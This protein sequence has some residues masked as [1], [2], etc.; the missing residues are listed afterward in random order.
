MIAPGP[1]SAPVPASGPDVAGRR[2]LSGRSVA[3]WSVRTDPPPAVAAR[4]EALLA[5]D[6]IARANRFLGEHLRSAYV[7]AH[8]ALRIL[9]GRY[10]GIAPRDVRLTCGAQGKPALAPPAGVGFNLSHSGHLATF[11]FALDCEL[12]IDVEHE[13]PVADLQAIAARFFSP[14]EALELSGVHPAAERERAFF[15]CWTRKEAYVKAVGTGLS[16]PLDSFRV[17]L[18]TGEPPRLMGV[19]GDRRGLED[20]NLH[21]LAPAPGYVAALAYRGA[22]RPVHVF[23]VQGA[24]ELPGQEVEPRS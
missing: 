10:A 8:G 6:E 19:G 12:G 21:A 24:A 16:T 2:A 18:R 23:P 22:R 3:V 1:G 14:D 20:W 15:R 4:L 7:A 11:A 17:T 13:R 9:L 5:P